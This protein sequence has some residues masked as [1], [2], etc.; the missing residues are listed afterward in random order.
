MI[1]E[2]PIGGEMPLHPDMLLNPVH[3]A[4]WPVFGGANRT[5]R[6]DTGRSAL[7]LALLDWKRRRPGGTLWLPDYVCPSV[8]YV[9]A[10]LGVKVRNYADGPHPSAATGLP[11]P[12]QMDIVVCVHYF[13]RF[14]HRMIDWASAAA[15]GLL[16]EDC[17]QAPYTPE[18]GR[19][20]DYVIASLRKWWPVSDGALLATRF[21]DLEAVLD[22]P[23]D[24]FVAQRTAAQLIR[25]LPQGE[26]NYLEWV[27]GSETRLSDAPPRRCSWM[28]RQILDRADVVEAS[29]RRRCNWLSLSALLG[30]GFYGVKPL[31]G[32]LGPDEVP[33]AFVIRVTQGRRDALRA[34]LAAR[35][36][37]CPVHWKL[38]GEASIEARCLASEMLSLPID[39][40]YD[41][42]DMRRVR[43]VLRDCMET[44][45][46]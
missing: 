25:D 6:C 3:G 1:F 41:E 12:C 11:A 45:N 34:A 43:D 21:D 15:Q 13:G 19:T 28:A 40:R 9:A 7:Q 5:V 35:A 42:S 31:H 20:G 39:Q 10:R 27:A 16:L 2:R 29:H 44:M 8:P 18:C 38:R 14:N 24:D 4:A 36:I 30:D 22:C 33:L 17:V 46:E 32:S 23:D 37:Y 26:R